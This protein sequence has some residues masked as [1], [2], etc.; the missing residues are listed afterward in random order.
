LGRKI[1]KEE[2][3]PLYGRKRGLRLCESNPDAKGRYS[4]EEYSDPRSLSKALAIF[5]VERTTCL[6]PAR[7]SWKMGPYLSAHSL[8]LSHECF[9]GMSGRLPRIGL[10]GKYQLPTRPLKRCIPGGPG[11]GVPDWRFVSLLLFHSNTATRSG[12]R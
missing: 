2:R 3:I 8:N 4:L 9:G 10:P 5:S 12:S 1:A 7:S 11:M 6:R